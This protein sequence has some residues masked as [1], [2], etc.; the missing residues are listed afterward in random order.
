MITHLN[1][2]NG[3]RV[4]GSSVFPSNRGQVLFVAPTA[5]GGSDGND[6]LS[7]ERPLETINGAILKCTANAGDLIVL[8]G[9]TYTFTA[10]QAVNVA[11]VTITGPPG[12]NPQKRRASITTSASDEVINV[13]AA[14]VEIA[15]LHVVVVTAKAGIDFTDAA[16]ELTIRNCSFDMFTAAA[17]TSTIGLKSL[18]TSGGVKNLVVDGCYFESLDAQGPYGDLNDVSYGTVQNTTSRHTGSTALADGWV[19]ATGAVD[20]IFDNVK[21]INGTSA[22]VTDAIDWTGNT[23]DGSIQLRNFYMSLGSQINTSATAD[24][25]LGIDSIKSQIASGASAPVNVLTA[26]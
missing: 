16:D 9:G 1:L 5:S 10:S 24:A 7:P 8:L 6:G 3:V 18:G 13:T 25:W 20:I 12:G 15:N 14:N 17:S 22:V 19:S 21:V 23:T 26:A 2:A 11:G 4:N